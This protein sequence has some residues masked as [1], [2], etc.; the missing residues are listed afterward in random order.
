[1]NRNPIFKKKTQTNNKLV[2]AGCRKDL[3]SRRIFMNIIID[4]PPS[5][6]LLHH[7][8]P[9]N[10][11]SSVFAATVTGIGLSNPSAPNACC[12]FGN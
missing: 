12:I 4:T 2:K 7:L 6:S 11:S 10:S 1:V 9:T 3:F 8:Y 5:G